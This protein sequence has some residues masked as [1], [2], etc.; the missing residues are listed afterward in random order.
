MKKRILFVDDE[1]SLLDGLR[2]SLHNQR[3]EWDMSFVLSGQEALDLMDQQSFDAVVTDMR[4]P[5]MNGVQLLAE[6]VRRYPETV[7]FILSGQSEDELTIKSVG[8]AH[9]YLSKPCD[10]S[11]LVTSLA[12]AFSLRKL[13]DGEQLRAIIS[14]TSSLPSLPSAYNEIMQYLQSPTASVRQVGEIITKDPASSAKVLQLVNSAFFGLG[15]QISSPADAATLLGLETLKALALTV[16]VFSQF[17]INPAG[18]A[19][20]S[21]E[22]IFSHSLAVG[23]LAKQIAISEGAEESVCNESFL[24]GLLHDIGKLIL[25]QS[26]PKKY[27]QML[28]LVEQGGVESHIAEQEVF[29]ATHGAVGAYLLG[30][31]GFADNVIEAVAYHHQP[32][33]SPMGEFSALTSIHAACVLHE[34]GVD[35]HQSQSISPVDLDYL[36]QAGVADRLEAWQAINSEMAEQTCTTP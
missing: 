10:T 5:A 34:M 16:G 11:V 14:S 25:A 21:I 22:A 36:Q 9:Q 6:L 23:T 8:I 4:M 15:R 20:C 31:W 13:L 7:R 3:R 26:M 19:N 24:A 33:L 27:V 32:G 35:Q 18:V 17:K 1:Q 2:R 30:L 29:G 28:A 12:R